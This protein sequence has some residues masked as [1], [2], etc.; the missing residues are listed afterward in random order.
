M[1]LLSLLYLLM[2][3]LCISG[4]QVQIRLQLQVAV[5][6]FALT[7]QKARLE[8]KCTNG[9]QA[10]STGAIVTLSAR[11]GHSRKGSGL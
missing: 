6:D 4:V 7:Q 2:K 3:N 10:K 8:C 11:R 1:L 9:F 5:Q